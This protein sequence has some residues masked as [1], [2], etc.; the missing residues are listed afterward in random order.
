MADSERYPPGRRADRRLN[1]APDSSDPA[2]TRKPAGQ[3]RRREPRVATPELIYEYGHPVVRP[4]GA[5]YVARVYG[6]P[7]RDG[8]WVG[9]LAFLSPDTAIVLRTERE[10]TQ[11]NR[12][13][14]TYWATGL[15]SVY[16]EGAL[17]RAREGAPSA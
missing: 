10:T 16:F 8:T 9:W 2:P 14:L 3:R 7:R 5:P 13:C 1:P 12:L 4:N 11:P 6:V 17:D 15:E